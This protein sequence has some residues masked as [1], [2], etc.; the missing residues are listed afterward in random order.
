MLLLSCRC[1]RVFMKLCEALNTDE[2]KSL[3]NQLIEKFD[4]LFIY[5]QPAVFVKAYIA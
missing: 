3:E 5:S 4:E 1:Y 2:Q